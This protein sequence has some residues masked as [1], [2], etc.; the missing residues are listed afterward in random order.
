MAFILSRARK[1]FA[2][3]LTLLTRKTEK[4]RLSVLGSQKE[5]LVKHTA[6]EDH[7]DEVHEEI[8]KPEVQE[9]R[10]A[11][12]D[13]LIVVVE[14]ASS[15]VKNETVDLSR[16][17][18]HLERVA[19]WMLGGNKRSNNEAHRTPGELIYTSSSVFELPKSV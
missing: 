6:W 3:V 11:I 16:R 2:I 8:V 1:A 10:S 14:H 18:N 19:E 5:C 9:L 17:Y 15:I 4:K 12:C 7:P 13:I